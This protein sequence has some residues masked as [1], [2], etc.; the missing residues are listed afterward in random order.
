MKSRKV[1]THIFSG[2]LYGIHIAGP[3]SGLCQA[4]NQ[5]MPEL[6]I[7]EGLDTEAGLETVIHEALHACNWAKVEYKVTSTAH[8]IS[9]FLWRL[10]YRYKG[11]R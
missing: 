7:M 1:R 5:E 9:R 4:P 6:T 11:E 10:G 2:V 3:T 8:D